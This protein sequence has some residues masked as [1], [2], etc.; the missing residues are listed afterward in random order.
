MFTYTFNQDEL[1]WTRMTLLLKTTKSY[2]TTVCDTG[3]EAMKDSGPWEMRNKWGK[4][5]NCPASCLE[6]VCRLQSREE[7]HKQGAAESLS[8]ADRD[9]S[10]ERQVREENFTEREF[11]KSSEGLL[12]YSADYWS[13]Y[14][15]KETH[16]WTRSTGKNKRLECWCSHRASSIACSH[17]PDWKNSSHR[18]MGREITKL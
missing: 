1:T 18:A 4:L 12:K 15:W 14:A 2:E 5:Y 7:K 16:G 17:Q 9:E 13:A 10:L 8:S 3:Y 6:T 11:C